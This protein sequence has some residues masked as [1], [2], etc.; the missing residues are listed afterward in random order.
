M[1]VLRIIALALAMLW[2]ISVILGANLFGGSIIHAL[3][4]IALIMF[5][6]DMMKSRRAV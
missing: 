4:V 2:F 1:S 3:I 6:V 5:I